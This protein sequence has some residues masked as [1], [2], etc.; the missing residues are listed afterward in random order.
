MN[1]FYQAAGADAA[2]RPEQRPLADLRQLD[3]A[4]ERGHSSELGAAEAAEGVEIGDA[5]GR[6]QVALTSH[7]VEACCRDRR[8][9]SADDADPA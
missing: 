9:G 2:G 8:S 5:E 6:L 4:Q 3:V 7:G 1:R